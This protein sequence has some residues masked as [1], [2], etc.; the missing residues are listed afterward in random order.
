LEIFKTSISCAIEFPGN[1]AKFDMSQI[2]LMITLS[3]KEVVIA[4]IAQIALSLLSQ[5][6][7]RR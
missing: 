5:I 2:T 7:D 4:D 6:R 1:G 3:N